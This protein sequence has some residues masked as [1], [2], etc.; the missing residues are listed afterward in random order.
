MY[1]SYVRFAR[2]FAEQFKE[3]NYKKSY[4]GPRGGRSPPL[5]LPPLGYASGDQC[6]WKLSKKLSNLLRVLGGKLNFKAPP[7]LIGSQSNRQASLVWLSIDRGVGKKNVK[8]RG[9]FHVSKRISGHVLKLP[10]EWTG[11]FLEFT[12]ISTD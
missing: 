8:F 2:Y 5:L 11:I 6:L 9:N 1:R 3:K 4:L 10:A 7:R 12:Y